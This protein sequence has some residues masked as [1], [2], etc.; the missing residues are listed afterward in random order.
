MHAAIAC[1]H[2]RER[3]RERDR[4]RDGERDRER[5][6]QVHRMTVMAIHRSNGS[7]S[8]SCGLKTANCWSPPPAH[9]LEYQVTLS[10]TKMI[11][12]LFLIGL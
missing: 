4:D 12:C 10:N 5:E 3:E 7:D 6:G 8:C 11:S 1:A 2:T 9:K